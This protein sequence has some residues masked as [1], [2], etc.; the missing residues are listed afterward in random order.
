MIV[1]YCGK[2]DRDVA[3]SKGKHYI[4]YAVK[5]YPNENDWYC[6]IDESGIVYPKDYDA[7]LFEVTDARV[8]RHWELGVSSNNKGEKAPCLAFDVWAHDV[9]FHGRMFE[10]DREALNLFFTHKTMMEEEFATPEIKNAAVALN[11]TFWVSDPQYDEAWEANP[12]NEL[13]R[14]PSTKE[15]FV[16]PIYT[17]RLSFSENR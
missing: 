6:V 15:L 8:S 4:C 10:G 16:N 12:M 1:K 14:C 11:R 7:D 13:T 5:F 9:L 3:L 17:G 2:S